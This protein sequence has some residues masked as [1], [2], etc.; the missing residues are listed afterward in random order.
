[1]KRHL[2]NLIRWVVLKSVEDD[3]A[4]RTAIVEGLGK[5]GRITLITPYGFDH[6]PPSGTLVA[7]FQAGAEEGNRFG[8]ATGQQKR[9]KGQELTEVIVGNP[10]IGSSIL[11]KANGDIEII[12]P[13]N[14]TLNVTGDLTVT[15][16][17]NLTSTVTGNADLSVAGAMTSTATG[18]AALSGSSVALGGAGGPAVARIGDDVLVVGGSSAGL[19]KIVSGSP[20]VTAT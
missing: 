18:S 9:F 7:A 2:K 19:H 20:N 5:D 14:T 4:F 8:M 1:M 11:F 15:V 13:Q 6:N 3:A 17:G 10:E 16:G 12:A